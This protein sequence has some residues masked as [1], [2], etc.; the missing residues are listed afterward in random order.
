M[1]KLPAPVRARDVSGKTSLAL[2]L[3]RYVSKGWKIR[4]N[5]SLSGDFGTLCQPRLITILTVSGSQ[6]KCI[7]D[8]AY[9]K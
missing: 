2:F 6:G 8:H 4:G 1:G 9:M 3:F 7:S 5:Y